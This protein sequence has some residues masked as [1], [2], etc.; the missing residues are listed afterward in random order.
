MELMKLNKRLKKELEHFKAIESSSKSVTRV[1]DKTASSL[2]ADRDLLQKTRTRLAELEHTCKLLEKERGALQSQLQNKEQSSVQDSAN[3]KAAHEVARLNKEIEQLQSQSR[4][5]EQ[6][7]MAKEI[8]ILRRQNNEMNA[9]LAAF[10]P[11]FFEE[12]EDMKF[13]NGNLVS[14]PRPP[15]CIVCAA[16]DSCAWLRCVVRRCNC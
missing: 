14:H 9:E 15:R 4:P 11:Q 1:A 3:A 16:H 7:R 6:E 13:Q 10:D 8:E 2:K 12:I 5:H